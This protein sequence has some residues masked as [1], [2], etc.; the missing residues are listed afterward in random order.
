[1]IPVGTNA[2]EWVRTWIR[3]GRP[4]LLRGEDPGWL[5]LNRN[6]GQLS[7]RGASGI[8]A[9]LAAKAGIQKQV[10]FHTLGVTAATE[11]IRNG[12]EVTHVQRYLGHE[13]ISTTTE[14]YVRHTADDLQRML[15]EHH[16]R[17]RGSSS[18]PPVRASRKRR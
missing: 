4:D 13:Q 5:F 7:K 9:K 14:H 17:E 1:M 11:C 16:P 12:A 2:L 6:G 3:R 15:R 18:R 8:L 10:T